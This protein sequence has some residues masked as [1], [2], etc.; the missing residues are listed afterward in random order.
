MDLPLLFF[1]LASHDLWKKT[2]TGRG[3]AFT[4]V[5]CPQVSAIFL[6][7]ENR[8]KKSSLPSYFCYSNILGVR[9]F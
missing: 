4:L 7:P 1:L 8:F 9:H 6:A 5:G 2:V 3:G